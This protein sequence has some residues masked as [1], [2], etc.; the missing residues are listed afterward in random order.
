MKLTGYTYACNKLTNFDY[1]VHAL[2]GNGNQNN[3]LKLAL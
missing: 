3:L 1:K 2:T